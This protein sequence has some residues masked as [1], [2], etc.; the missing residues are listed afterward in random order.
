MNGR[1]V[2]LVEDNPSD[3]ALT[4]R[5]FGKAGI[6]GLVAVED[7]K[8]AL[9]YLFREGPHAERPAGQPSLILLDLNLPKLDGL[10]VLRRLREDER[11]RHTPVVVLTSSVEQDD[12][13]S[14]YALGANSYIRKP[15]EFERFAQAV[16]AIGNYWLRLN[17]TPVAGAAP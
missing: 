15:V 10:A 7:G 16:E 6:T 8:E 2:L 9:D 12:V 3:V 1:T 14:S 17:Q 11:T 4:R 5:A 13:A